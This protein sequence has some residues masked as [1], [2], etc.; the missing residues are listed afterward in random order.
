M[1][2]V[3]LDLDDLAEPALRDRLV[4][5]LRAGEERHLAGA[6][7]EDAGGLDR[8]HDPLGGGE[9]DAERLLAEEVLARGGRVEVELLVEV[10]GDGEVEDV[11][12]VVL[13]QVAAVGRLVGDR[14][15]AVEPTQRLGARVA[16]GDELRDDGVVLQRAPAPD[17]GRQLAAHEPRADDADADAILPRH[18]SSPWTACLSARTMA[19]GSGCWMTLRP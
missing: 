17:G 7:H 15:D 4:G 19:A 12:R 11:D 8:R 6:A 18:A 9:I 5:E 1:Q 13:E 10:V 2:E 16:H 14:G 3:V